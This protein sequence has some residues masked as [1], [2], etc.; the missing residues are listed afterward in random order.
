MNACMYRHAHGFTRKLKTE[1]RASTEDDSAMFREGGIM[2]RD[3]IYTYT[4]SASLMR[5]DIYAL[6]AIP[7]NLNK[8]G[9]NFTKMF[10]FLK[11]VF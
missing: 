5:R 1:L 11:P 7:G 9:I 10:G 4:Y 6:S 8:F 2:N 3:E